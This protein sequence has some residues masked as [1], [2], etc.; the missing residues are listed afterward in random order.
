MRSHAAA[1]HVVDARP[2]GPP[3]RVEHARRAEPR[4]CGS[5]APRAAAGITANTARIDPAPSH[6]EI[7]SNISTYREQVSR[8][9]ST[10][11]KQGLVRRAGRALL[12]PDIQR[13]EKI[14]SEVRRAG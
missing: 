5:A 1:P 7:A 13:L 2:D 8:E 4:A 14:V 9:L 11:A 12:V 10:M 3:V 6:A